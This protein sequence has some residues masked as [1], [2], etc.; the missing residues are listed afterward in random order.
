MSE[1]ETTS[2][3]STPARGAGSEDAHPAEGQEAGVRVPDRLDSIPAARAFLA[4]LLDGWGI[5]DEVID[6]ASLL[7]SELMSNAVKHGGGVVDLQIEAED[8]LL[9][10]GVHDNSDGA[11]T[12]TEAGPSSPGGRGMWIVQSVAHDWGTDPDASGKTVWFELNLHEPA[13]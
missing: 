10:V 11:P 13:S 1:P 3:A 8:G 2:A 5:A 12:I 9:H 4:R 6:D 7:A